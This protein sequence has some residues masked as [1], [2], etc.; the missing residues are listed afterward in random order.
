GA[1]A[2]HH[3][4]ERAVAGPEEAAAGGAVT[5][6]RIGLES[7]AL[8]RVATEL[9]DDAGRDGEAP[10]VRRGDRDQIVAHLDV[11]VGEAGGGRREALHLEDGQ[12]HVGLLAESDDPRRMADL[13]SLRPHPDLEGASP[14][15]V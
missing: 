1:V 13:L 14:E 7:P 11:L 9:A 8:L 6:G 4:Q 15:R 2:L 10:A 3:A 12:V 5:D